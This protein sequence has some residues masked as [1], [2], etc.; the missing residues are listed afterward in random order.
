MIKNES[1]ASLEA[2]VKERLSEKRFEHTLGV[3]R[4]AVR[5]ADLCGVDSGVA[6][7]AALLHD[8]TKEYSNA[9]QL[10]FLSALGIELDGE[11]AECPQIWHSYTA[12]HVISRD[13]PE[14]ADEAVLSA[15]DKHTVGSPDMT[16]LEKII[17]LADFIEDTRLYPAS[18]AVREYVF[19][20]MK[21]GEVLSNLHVLDC[22]IISS[23]NYTVEHLNKTKRKVN[24]K[25][26]L[27]KNALLSK[28]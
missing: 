22:A 6:S 15:I 5:L 7:V 3:R 16:V 9:E 2:K 4:A 24:S 18:R 12:R 21:L 11:D 14:Y 25:T 19:S 27:T 10:S 13:F 20:N 26:L 8:I 23:I 1:L 28:I 17:F